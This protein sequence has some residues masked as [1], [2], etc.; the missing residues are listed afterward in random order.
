MTIADTFMMI[1]ILNGFALSGAYFL[2]Q[3]VDW[4]RR[5]AADAIKKAAILLLYQGKSS[6]PQESAGVRVV[7]DLADGNFAAGSNSRSL[8][9]TF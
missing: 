3:L 6:H 1:M 5:H 8:Q 7:V 2:A 9:G 4:R